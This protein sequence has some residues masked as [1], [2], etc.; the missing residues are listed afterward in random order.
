MYLVEN[1]QSD[2]GMINKIDCKQFPLTGEID[3]ADSNALFVVI[4]HRLDCIHINRNATVIC[5]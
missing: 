4:A 5:E 2:D 1:L 3:K